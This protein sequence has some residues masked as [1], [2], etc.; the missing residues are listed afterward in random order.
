MQCYV[1]MYEYFSGCVDPIDLSIPFLFSTGH[2]IWPSSCVV[3][4]WVTHTERGQLSINTFHLS[5]WLTVE[6]IQMPC[7]LLYSQHWQCC[8]YWI[9]IGVWTLSEY[10]HGLPPLCW[11]AGVYTR[12]PLGNNTSHYTVFLTL[13]STYTHIHC[14]Y[15]V[16]QVSAYIWMVDWS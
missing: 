9:Y 10:N 1:H 4:G 8:I 14:C 3:S 15:S 7:R 11:H 6:L 5:S 13:H 16:G 12:K 2:K